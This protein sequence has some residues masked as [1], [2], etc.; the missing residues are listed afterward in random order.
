MMPKE[1]LEH[2]LLKQQRKLRAMMGNPKYS[3]YK[4]SPA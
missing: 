4:D 1:F 3:E 2:P